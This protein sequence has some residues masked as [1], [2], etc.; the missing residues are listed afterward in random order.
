MLVE[1]DMTMKHN[2]IDQAEGGDT[3]EQAERDR[4]NENMRSLERQHATR[5]ERPPDDAFADK[6]GR[7]ITVRSWESGDFLFA[8]A[9]DTTRRP[10]PEHID[11]GQAGY[12]NA[13][14]ER[15]Y[16][17]S[18]AR[19]RIHDVFTNPEY[20]GAGIAGKMLNQSEQFAQRH[21]AKEIYGA[22]TDTDAKQFWEQQA[23]H[24]WQLVQNGSTLEAHKQL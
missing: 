6:A 1:M 15:S 12:L 9:Y 3:T 18:G 16:D 13:S 10:L 21:G 19:V 20:R 4:A 2:K 14:V 24:G 11:I 23:D 8:R 7:P 17:G 5:T 22:I